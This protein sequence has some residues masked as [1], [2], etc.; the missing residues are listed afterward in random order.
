MMKR[1]LMNKLKLYLRNLPVIKKEVKEAKIFEFKN[2]GFRGDVHFKDEEIREIIFELV[3][4]PEIKVSTL[5]YR[6]IPKP[7][8]SHPE[9]FDKKIFSTLYANNN[10]NIILKKNN[11]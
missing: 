6:E 9:L 3:I 2:G 4:Q 7:F 1:I 5:E 8:H 10:K 11:S